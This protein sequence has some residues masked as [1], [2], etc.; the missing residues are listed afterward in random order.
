M[1]DKT[2]RS[3]PGRT[4][5]G[6]RHIP[7]RELDDMRKKEEMENNKTKE[8]DKQDLSSNAEN[9]TITAQFG[10]LALFF[11]KLIRVSQETFNEE[12]AAQY[13]KVD[14][15]TIRYY[16]KRLR[17]LPYSKVGRKLVFTKRELDRFLERKKVSG[18]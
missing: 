16:A 8:T 14:K 15:R 6:C 3:F 18:V 7:G 9:S 10:Q 17:Q 5:K 1:A 2:R 11:D 4:D 12:E 13:L